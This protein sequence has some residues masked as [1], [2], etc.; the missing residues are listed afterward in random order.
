MEEGARSRCGGE[1]TVK[2]GSEPI[3]NQRREEYSQKQ[4]D[5]SVSNRLEIKS[6]AAEGGRCVRGLNSRP[7]QC[8]DSIHS[9][10][11]N[12]VWSIST[13]LTHSVSLGARG[14]KML[15]YEGNC[16]GE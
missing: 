2:E 14:G 12:F 16:W 7:R 4:P 3:A 11:S 13:S 9:S 5:D 10:P 1:E 15:L 6:S 8:L